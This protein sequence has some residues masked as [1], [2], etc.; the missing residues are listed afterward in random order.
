VAGRRQARLTA[1]LRGVEHLLVVGGG[2]GLEGEGGFGWRAHAECG[3]LVL[4]V[5]VGFLDRDGGAYRVDWT[6]K[7]LFFKYGLNS[8]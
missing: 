5:N 4:L 3:L 6:W 7:S 1:L 2:R 8:G